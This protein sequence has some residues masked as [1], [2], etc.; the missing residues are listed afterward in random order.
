[1]TTLQLTKTQTPEVNR[2]IRRYQKEFVALERAHTAHTVD[3][4]GHVHITVKPFPN[5]I[6]KIMSGLWTDL[7]NILTPDQ[8]TAAKQLDFTRFFPTT[9]RST[10]HVEIWRDGRGEEHYVESEDPGPNAT[11]PATVDR[12]MPPRFRSYMPDGQ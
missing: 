6:E 12:P 1:M 5:G 11:P 2:T 7:G 3:K 10:V 8:L 9:G 4:A